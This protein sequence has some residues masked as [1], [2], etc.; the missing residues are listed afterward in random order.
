MK[1]LRP[2]DTRAVEALRAAGLAGI[3]TA[4]LCAALGF[5]DDPRTAHCFADR[6]AALGVEVEHGF[7]PLRW[8]LADAEADDAAPTRASELGI[9]AVGRLCPFRAGEEG[10]AVVSVAR[11]SFIDGARA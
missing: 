9:F 5:K 8:W 3:T 1:N 6:V 4:D 7:R 2:C 11:V 10:R